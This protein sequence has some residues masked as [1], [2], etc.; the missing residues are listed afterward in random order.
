[1]KK[2]REKVDQVLESEKPN[3]AFSKI[4]LK[5]KIKEIKSL[6]KK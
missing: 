5:T 6:N 2:V 4:D 3:K 1:M